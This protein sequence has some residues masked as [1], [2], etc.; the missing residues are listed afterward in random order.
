MNDAMNEDN[1]LMVQYQTLLQYMLAKRFVDASTLRAFYSLALVAARG[2]PMAAAAAKENPPAP[3]SERTLNDAVH[4]LNLSVENANLKIEQGH[5]D[6]GEAVVFV[7][8]AFFF[9]LQ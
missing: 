3:C 5:G 6:D 4:V 9:A 1:S 7:L 8:S 2:G